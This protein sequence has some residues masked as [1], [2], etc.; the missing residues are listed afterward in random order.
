MKRLIAL[1][2]RREKE[3]KNY[4]KQIGIWVIA[5]IGVLL[6]SLPAPAAAQQFTFAATLKGY[7]ENPS[8]FST[9]SG[10][11]RLTISEDETSFDFELMFTGLETTATASHMHLG[12][13]WQNGPVMIFFC[14]GGGRPACQPGKLITGTVTASDVGGGAAAQGI[15]AEELGKVIDAIRNGATYAN[16]HTTARSGGEIRGQVLAAQ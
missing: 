7:N 13:R 2:G 9:G 10:E 4:L 11:F 14:G 1:L 12:E 16:V 5:S 8:L 6:V 3:E 15:G